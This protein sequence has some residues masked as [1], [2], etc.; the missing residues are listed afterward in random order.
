MR[1]S[2]HQTGATTWELRASDGTVVATFNDRP[3]QDGYDQACTRLGTILAEHHLAAGDGEGDAGDGMLPDR[4]VS[5][6]GLCF[7]EDTPGGRDFSECAWS[8][9]D[10][11]A[12]LVPLMLMTENTDYGHLGAEL[13]GFVEEFHM[14]GTT[15]QGSGRFY[16]SEVGIQARDILRAGRMGVSV[17][18][19]EN[20]DAEFKEECTEQ[21][22][23]G[24]CTSWDF[25]I[26]FNAYEIGG[27]TM[28]PF[29]CFENASI[30]LDGTAAA[31]IRASAVSVP[32][33]P[34][35]AWLT[36]PEPQLGEEWFEGLLGDDV[37]VPQRDRQ[38]D[39]YA[40]A[41][42]LTIRDDGLVYAHLTAWGQCHIGNPWGQG[43]CASAAPSRNGYAEF[44]TSSVVCDDGT[45]VPTGPLTVGCEHSFE[46]TAQGVRDHM[47]HAGMGWAD[48]HVVDGVHGPWLSGVLRP[49]I[50][51]TQLRVLRALALSGEWVDD[52]AAV[53]TVN[54]SGLPVQRA[55][56]ASA[57][58]GRTIPAGALRS[59]AKPGGLTSLVG[60]NMVQ[61]CPD[62]QKRLSAGA[63]SSPMTQ[64]DGRRI[65][66]LLANLDRRTKHLVAGEADAV[67]RRLV[68]SRG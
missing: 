1:Y 31:T 30:V 53:L 10:P 46:F 11:T 45:S 36:L 41:V 3:G 49:G 25:S 56:A 16:D 27:V 12:S 26:V 23:D 32:A 39:V 34:P 15:P 59:S 14:A 57:F 42:P 13:A 17:D 22:E 58:V 50:T 6:E 48:V 52:L 68:A 8:W 4:W 35:R 21:D 54:C 29:P 7:S 2:I 64:A 44:L 18:P 40:Q 24:F 51:E 20:V 60:A 38:G 62:C 43:V 37:L 47:A 67:E 63:G 5:D 19:T 55:L 61:S 28:C 66:H 9:R 65:M 33:R